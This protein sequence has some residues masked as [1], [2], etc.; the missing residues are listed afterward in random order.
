VTYVELM[1]VVH[2]GCEAKQTACSMKSFWR[3][4]GYTGR[5]A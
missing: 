2:A 3:C 4:W 1:D 5:A